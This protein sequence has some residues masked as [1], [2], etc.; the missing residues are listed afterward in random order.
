[1]S[2]DAYMKRSLE[3]LTQ[4]NAILEDVRA[5]L[6]AKQGETAV[7]TKPAAPTQP[8]PIEDP[9]DPPQ[10]ETAVADKAADPTNGSSKQASNHGKD[11]AKQ[12]KPKKVT[13]DNVRS[14]LMALGKRE[15]S[16]AAVALLKKYDSTSVSALKEEDYE[17]II[18]DCTP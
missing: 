11:D 12:E 2:P 8:A 5:L 17:A 14:A 16:E 3:L 1:M 9:A 15:G 18:A 6:T 10:S 13:A 4:M 7:A